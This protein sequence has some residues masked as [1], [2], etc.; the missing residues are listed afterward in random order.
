MSSQEVPCSL[1]GHPAVP[2]GPAADEGVTSGAGSQA[3]MGGERKGRPEVGA[4]PSGPWTP[5]PQ[6]VHLVLGGPGIGKRD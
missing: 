2:K 6:L 3:S 4:V 5:A 1:S